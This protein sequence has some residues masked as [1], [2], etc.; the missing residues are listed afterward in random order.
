MFPFVEDGRVCHVEVVILKRKTSRDPG[1]TLVPLEG[2]AG[3][4]MTY[5]VSQSRMAQ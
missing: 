2:A 3:L 4:P 5:I 1:T